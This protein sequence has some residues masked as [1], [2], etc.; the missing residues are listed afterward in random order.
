MK[1]ERDRQ[2]LLGPVR[3]GGKPVSF[4]LITFIT[5]RL[6][7]FQPKAIDGI[8]VSNVRTSSDFCATNIFCGA[9]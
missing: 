3:H 9:L 1:A 6:T 7:M 8:V 2:R 5:P 4:H